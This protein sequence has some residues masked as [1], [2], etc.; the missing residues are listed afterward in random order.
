MRFI[1][2]VLLAC[3][4]CGAE[5][6]CNISVT[7]VAYGAYTPASYAPLDGMGNISVACDAAQGQAI[8]YTIVL[9]S[10][11]SG[12]YGARK[13]GY[14]GYVINYNNYLDAARTKIWGDGNA[15]SH[16]LSDSYSGVGGLN[17]RNYTVYG[18]IFGN[19][20]IPA[21]NYSDSIIVTLSY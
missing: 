3:T 6:V 12:A 10:G 16:I 13:M 9:N 7:N 5:A 20:A 8:A 2:S 1:L 17:V 18:R 15:G 19:Q 4:S 21:G 14:V 11:S